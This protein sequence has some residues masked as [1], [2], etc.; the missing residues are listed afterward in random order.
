M[1]DCISTRRVSSCVVGHRLDES[2]KCLDT[3]VDRDLP[4]FEVV[5]VDGV[6][7]SVGFLSLEKSLESRSLPAAVI[8]EVPERGELLER[9]DRVL[10]GDVGA[11]TLGRLVTVVSDPVDRPAGSC[12]EPSWKWRCLTDRLRF[13]GC[14]CWLCCRL[15]CS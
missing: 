11:N 8:A 9:L 14:L 7:H 2:R 15:V 13:I 3:S 1:R 6:R 4:R 10:D 5:L 12:E